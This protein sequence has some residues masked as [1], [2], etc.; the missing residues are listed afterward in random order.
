MRVEAIWRRNTILVGV[1]AFL[2]HNGHH[3]HKRSEAKQQK[4]EDGRHD[5]HE[6]VPSRAT[7]KS[8]NIMVLRPPKHS[9]LMVFGTPKAPTL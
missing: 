4:Q 1:R 7:P 5:C 8:A 6:S 2:L 3:L 9:N